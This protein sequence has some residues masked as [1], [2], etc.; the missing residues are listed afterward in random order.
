MVV[1][2]DMRYSH[3]CEGLHRYVD[4]ADDQVYVYAFVYIDNAPK[5][6]ACFDQPDL[7]APYTFTRDACRRTGR[8]WATPTRPPARAGPLG[9]RAAP[10]RRRPT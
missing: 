8:C 10:R 4:P 5:V 3:E 1:A 6:F 2:A 7:K 9:A